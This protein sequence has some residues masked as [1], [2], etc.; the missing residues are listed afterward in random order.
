M[1]NDLA[2]LASLLCFMQNSNAYSFSL[3]E[4]MT[5]KLH[6]VTRLDTISFVI[7]A[8]PGLPFMN[9]VVFHVNLE[10]FSECFS[11]RV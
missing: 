9:P 7:H 4:N 3:N 11:T 2:S 8:I 1:G 10:R 5:L 6:I